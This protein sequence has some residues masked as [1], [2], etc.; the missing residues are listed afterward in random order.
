M[1]AMARFKSMLTTDNPL[2]KIDDMSLLINVVEN[3]IMSQ[4]MRCDIFA[5]RY[6]W[7]QKIVTALN[8]YRKFARAQYAL[9]EDNRAI[10]L[11]DMMNESTLAQLRTASTKARTAARHHKLH[12]DSELLEQSSSANERARAVQKAMIMVGPICTSSES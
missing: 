9:N 5:D 8:R 2:E 6:T 10:N 12:R 4:L 7:T 3:D 11:I 1:R